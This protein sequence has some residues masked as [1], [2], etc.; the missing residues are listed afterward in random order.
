MTAIRCRTPFKNLLLCLASVVGIAALHTPAN[1]FKCPNVHI[2]MD[3]SGSM[4]T[5]MTTSTGGMSTRWDIAK[6]Q[7]K[8]LLTVYDGLSPVGLSIFPPTSGMCSSDTPVRP[9]Y[10]TKSAIAMSLDANGPSGS[11]PSGTAM[12]N[13]AMLSELQDPTRRQY[14]L[15]LTDGGPGCGGEPDTATGTANE[16][17]KALMQSPPIYTFVIGIGNLAASEKAALTMMADAGGKPSMTADKY[18][19]AG[20][21]VELTNS[22]TTI[23]LMINGENTGCSDVLPDGGGGM[24]DMSMGGDD[25]SGPPRDMAG[26]PR[27]MAGP[28]RDMSTGPLD[29]SGPPFDLSGPPRDMAGPPRD[30][31]GPP[32]DM[33]GPRPDGGSSGD[34]RPKID[35]ILPKTMPF[36]M[37]GPA[38]IT[39]RNFE[40]TVPTSEFSLEQGVTSI[41][42]SA[43]LQD[44]HLAQIIIPANLPVGTY[45][46]VVKNPDGY[47]DA[48]TDGFTV[49]PAKVGC[50]C[51]L[52]PQPPQNTA[53]LAVL[54]M[55]LLAGRLL[56][57]ARRRSA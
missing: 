51:S 6:N 21:E 29:L 57:R 48:L 34:P 15:L 4:S 27:D 53:P 55:S 46:V 36:G 9:A 37:G 39:G 52:S 33:S 30:M 13:A 42:L 11:T 19:P 40:P 44:S 8:N 50:A 43:A 3:R 56:L 22:L 26:P 2:V 25:M 49:T 41:P 14:V 16:I 45:T 17:R 38:E 7:L 54:F 23:A 1:A 35:W 12:R 32:R 31:A 47:V 24:S 20:T 18:Y 10:F 5:N 28:P